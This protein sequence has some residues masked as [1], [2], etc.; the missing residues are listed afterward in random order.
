MLAVRDTVDQ[1]T[2]AVELEDSVQRAWV[3]TP[4][5]DFTISSAWDAIWPMQEY[6]W[7]RKCVWGSRVPCKIAVFMWKL[8]NN[9]LPF[10]DA[11]Q[12]LGFQLPTKCQFCLGGESQDHVM[13]ECTL[14]T[15]V[16]N[17]F[18]KALSVPTMGPTGILGRLQQW[19]LLQPPGTA[20]GM[21]C[22]VLPS[23]ICWGLW[24]ARNMAMY[25]G[26]VASP[27]QV[28]REV[29]SLLLNI[30]QVYPFVQ[31]ARD[32]GELAHLG[33]LLRTELKK[34]VLPRWVA[35]LRP[36]IGCVK[37]NVDGSSLGNPGLSGAGAVFRDSGGS[38][39]CAFSW[40]LG[41]RTN[42]EAEAMALLEGL[43]LSA[44]F[45]S[46]HVEM[47]SQV[48]LKMVN[49]DGRVPWRLWR[50]VSRIKALMLGRQI[51]FTVYREANAVADALACLPSTTHVSQSFP[52]SS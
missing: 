6:L 35:W 16:W 21:V 42:M 44:T 31:V 13:S 40:F 25:E 46:L 14:A 10:P 20:R 38:I 37:L 43:L 28:C 11:L 48:L 12:R 47:D 26:A 1:F 33:F 3:L 45:H 23:L 2:Q 52:P 5:G 27:A 24:K 36:P 49:G 19:W 39:L 29:K 34:F 22:R 7:T 17:F 4:S 8:L 51:T 15:E 9:Y 50:T 18:S 41:S 30:S 32:D